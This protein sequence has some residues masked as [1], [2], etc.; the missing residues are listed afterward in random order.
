MRQLIHGLNLDAL[1]TS[2]DLAQAYIP[3]VEPTL[4]LAE[5]PSC[6]VGIAR[7]WL[8]CLPETNT[9]PAICSGI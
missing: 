2:G 8:I 1:E 5:L 3:T 9:D 4:R 6:R 7:E